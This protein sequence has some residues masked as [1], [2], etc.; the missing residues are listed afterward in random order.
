MN[1]FQIAGGSVRG[2]DHEMAGRNNQDSYFW[3]T[4][5]NLIVAAVCDGC[6]SGRYS[7]AGALLGARMLVMSAWAQKRRLG[8]VDQERLR[9]E[10]AS[11]LSVVSEW[12]SDSLSSAVSDFFLFT[13][14]VLVMDD[15]KTTVLSCGDG[16][17][18]RCTLSEGLVVHSIDQN[19]AP[20]YIGYAVTNPDQRDRSAFDRWEWKT[21]DIES[22]L[23]GTDG[24]DNIPELRRRRLP[25]KSE[26]VGAL[27]QFWA[28]DRYFRNSFAVSR[29][30]RLI[31]RN[32]RKVDYENR[33]LEEQKG[34]LPDDTTL[35]VVRRCKSTSEAS[36]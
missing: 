33:L 20:S 25:G 32:S 5:D 2:R 27:S 24:V 31:N 13:S 22:I 17:I 9:M 30:L 21:A 4:D 18:N 26:E 19:N 6:G 34:L 28:D 29:R 1:G 14:I 10:V 12:V 3:K 23:V 16:L 8:R 11:K 15:E 7:E 36:A 35:V